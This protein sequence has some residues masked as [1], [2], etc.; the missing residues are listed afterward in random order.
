MPVCVRV[1]TCVCVCVCVCACVCSRVLL[2]W[3]RDRRSYWHRHQKR[4]EWC[5]WTLLF[6]VHLLFTFYPSK[7]GA[8]LSLIQPVCL[9]KFL[10]L[11]LLGRRY[12]QL[13][14]SAAFQITCRSA[15]CL[16]EVG[17]VRSGVLPLFIE[18]KLSK[19]FCHLLS[20]LVKYWLRKGVA[21]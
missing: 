17:G 13:Y 5:F 10:E 21:A 6:M 11:D 8:S 4:A 12:T 3:K 7:W 18:S 1:C 20:I 19:H 14:L 16:K 15:S 9:A 2:Q